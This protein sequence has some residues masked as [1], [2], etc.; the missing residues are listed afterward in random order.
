[1]VLSAGDS[2]FFNEV[3]KPGGPPGPG[4]CDPSLEPGVGGNPFCFE[5][6]TCCE[7]GRWACNNPDGSPSCN[8]GVVCEGC[9]GSGAACEDHADC[10]S[11][12]CLGNGTCK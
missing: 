7:D 8:P 1:M 9:A 4:C 11:G 5:G 3:K 12:K 6:H 10:C 2:D